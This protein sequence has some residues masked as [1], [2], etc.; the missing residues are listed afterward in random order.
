M[1]FDSPAGGND[2]MDMMAMM[3]NVE[4]YTSSA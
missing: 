1:D 2:Q 3:N 4:D